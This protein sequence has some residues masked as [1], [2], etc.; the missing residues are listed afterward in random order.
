M[1]PT[2]L[3][4]YIEKSLFKKLFLGNMP[5]H[6]QVLNEEMEMSMDRLV[7]TNQIYDYNIMILDVSYLGRGGIEVF[8]SVQSSIGE[9]FE[10]YSISI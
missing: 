6:L 5:E 7:S 8:V 1:T 3:L 4:Q 2:E 9:D 10:L